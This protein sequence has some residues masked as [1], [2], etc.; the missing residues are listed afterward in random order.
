MTLPI[1]LGSALMLI[2]L[3]L[4]AAHPAAAQ[5]TINFGAAQTESG[6]TDVAAAGTTV[7]ADAFGNGLA[8]TTTVNGVAFT[9]NVQFS[10]TNGSVSLATT[11]LTGAY[12]GFAVGYTPFGN[13]S[14]NYQDVLRGAIFNSGDP[15]T[16]TVTGLTGGDQYLAE[17]FVNDPRGSTNRAETLSGGTTLLYNVGNGT[18]NPNDP[19]AGAD[20]QFATASFTA[21]VTGTAMFTATSTGGSTQVNAFQLR[22][23]GAAPEP[24]PFA[25]LA[26]GVLGLGGLALRARKRVVD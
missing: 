8:G 18:A 15:A 4:A 16:F 19:G 14:A 24:S 9:N 3:G 13:L 21:D 12:N 25:G 2:A 11:G 6:D 1:K 26:L 23:L 10:D 17:F 22:D 20:G 7:L 5:V